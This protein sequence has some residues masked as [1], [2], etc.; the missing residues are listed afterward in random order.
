MT[1]VDAGPLVALLNRRD[2]Y[3]QLS[4]SIAGRLPLEPLVSTWPCFTEAM[5]LSLRAGGAIAQKN[6]WQLH[7]DGKLRLYDL[8]L[9]TAVRMAELMDKFDDLPMDLA[10][11]SLI[12]LAEELGTTRVFTFDQDFRIYLFKDGRHVDIIE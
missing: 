3:H 12:A 7:L 11:A 6:L 2:P 1:L 10:D 5:Y 9:P 4:L 8:S